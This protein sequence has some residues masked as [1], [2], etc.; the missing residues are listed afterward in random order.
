MNKRYHK[1][2]LQIKFLFYVCLQYFFLTNI[3]AQVTFE[4]QPSFF[5][6]Q[7]EMPLISLN[8]TQTISVASYGATIND[9]VD[10]LAAIQ[11]AITAAK[12]AASSL[13]PV[14]VVFQNGV[15]NIMPTSTTATHA[16]SLNTVNNVVFDGNGAEIRNNNPTIGFFEVRNCTN[17]IFKNLNFDYSVLPF[18]QGVV[19]SKNE[20]NNTFTIYIDPSFPQITETRFADAPEAWGCLKDAT[21]KLKA[22]AIN[23]YPYVGFTTTS[24]ANTYRISTPSN[25]YTSKVEVGDYFVQIARHNGRTIFNTVNGKNVTYL[26]INIYSSPAGSF[27]GQDNREFNIINCNVI[28]K[29]GSGRVQSGNADCVHITGGTFGPWV[30]GCRFEAQTD[31]AVN[32]KHTKR[33]IMEIISPTVIRV[34]FTVKTTDKLVI[35]NP[36]TGTPL[37]TPNNITSV[38]NLGSNI[39]EV[40]F[41]SP[42]NATVTG[43]HQS[44]DKAYLTNSSCESFVFRNNVF[45]NGRRYGMLLQSSYGQI[46]NCTFENQSSSGIKIENGV[47]WTEG[48]I[49]NNIE[50]I[51]NSFINCGFDASY[52]EDSLS[53]AI[54]TVVS[55][56]KSPCTTAITFCGTE[57]VGNQQEIKNITISGNNIIYNKTGINLQNIDVG[58]LNSNTYTHNPQDTTLEVGEVPNNLRNTNNSNLILESSTPPNS[59]EDKIKLITDKNLLTVIKETNAT[60]NYNLTLSSSTGQILQTKMFNEILTT[61]DV[62]TYQT[63]WYL[64]TLENNNI[65]TSIKIVLD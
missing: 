33:D 58:V 54:S 10:D 49:A 31:D 1:V 62:S 8:T 39:F 34:K 35:F 18:T 9:G 56:L 38:V 25:S 45:K 13:N 55:K 40:T 61:L 44:A 14:L 52:I 57:P 42:H 4:P 6:N 41:D 17:V 23:L 60:K 48:Y 26:N 59:S 21:G 29:P 16:L 32:L 24:F 63:G 27:N 30:Q 51:N 47:D 46:K 19:T 15:Y 2:S 22:G 11:A 20:S 65:Q 5:R 53:A 64:L 12:S 3:Y 7:R 43:E 50:I 36:R 28:P 37:A